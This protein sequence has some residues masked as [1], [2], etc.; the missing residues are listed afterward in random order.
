MSEAGPNQQR[1]HGDAV[2]RLLSHCEDG[3]GEPSPLIMGLVLLITG[4]PFLP[5]FT[6]SSQKLGL[7]SMF[8]YRKYTV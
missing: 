2:L 8:I 6:Q 1:N 3:S 4:R 7:A 5:I